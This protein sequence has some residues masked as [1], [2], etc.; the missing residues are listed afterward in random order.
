[1]SEIISFHRKK[2]EILR[3]AVEQAEARLNKHRAELGWLKQNGA[4]LAELVKASM[5]VD[6]ALLHHREREA[7]L[8]AHGIGEGGGPGIAA[9]AAG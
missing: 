5:R 6:S 1:M 9:R 4:L 8:T 7:A 3:N 2:A